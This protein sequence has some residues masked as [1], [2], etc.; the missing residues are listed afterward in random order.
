MSEP[1]PE[2]GFARVVV[3][4]YNV[5]ATVRTAD[6][7]HKSA[8]DGMLIWCKYNNLPYNSMGDVD[9]AAVVKACF[10]DPLN[11]PGNVAN[12]MHMARIN[13]SI[14][15]VATNVA[16][17]FWVADNPA[18]IED[19]KKAFLNVV[20]MLRLGITYGRRWDMIQLTTVFPVGSHSAVMPVAT[21]GDESR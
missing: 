20:I 9:P 3:S 4:V 18:T 14:A 1:P 16:Y 15:Q 2:T 17:T 7:L 19:A 5:P 12:F 21:G 11:A 10:A 6:D 8:E 13:A